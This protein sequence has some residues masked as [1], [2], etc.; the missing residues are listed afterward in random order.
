[1]T[2]LEKCEKTSSANPEV[3][4]SSRARR[5][6]LGKGAAAAPFLITL[7]SQPALGATCFTPSRSLSKNTSV[8]QQGKDG[9]CTGA[10]SYQAYQADQTPGQSGFRWPASAQPTAPLHPT[11]A[12]GNSE[13]VTKFT[14]QV[15]GQVV[16]QTFGEA[17]SV[18]GGGQV[19]RYLIAA[20]LNKLGGNGA[21]I[22]DK[23]ITVTGILTMWQEYAT[24]G[25]YEPFAG[26]KWYGA[27]INGYLV[28]N[29]I[30]A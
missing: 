23:A 21:T 26:V 30:V 1:M 28:S 22:S 11:F 8:S 20:Y 12:E 4:D 7:A 5:R 19:H 25:Y 13:G 10:A 6:F 15:G 2:E 3:E 16:S 9:E 17:L 24:K 27:E 14:K 29:G 18:N